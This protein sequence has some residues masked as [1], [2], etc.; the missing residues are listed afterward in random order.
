ML[1]SFPPL[2]LPDD[3]LSFE[4]EQFLGLVNK[5]CGNVFKELMEVLSINT[6]YKLLLVEKDIL[7]VFQKKY[8]ELEKITERACLHLDDGSILLKPGLRLDFDRFITALRAVYEGNHHQERTRSSNDDLLSLFTTLMKS[9]HVNENNNV[10]S[11][12]SFL[13]VFI[14]NILSNIFKNKNNYRYD[15]SVVHFAQSLYILG[16]RNA[17]EF[18]R[19]NLQGALPSLS[20]LDGTLTKSGM[21]FEEAEFRFNA[22]REHQKSSGYQTAVCSEDCTGVIKKITYNAMTNTFT[23]F[24]APLDHGLPIARHFQTDSF[25]QLKSWFETK[26]KSCYLNVHM[27][28]PLFESS[29]Y[30]SPFLLAAYGLS[31][32]FH[33]IDVLNRWL[34][35]LKKSRESDVR[36]VAFSTDCDSRY[37]LA[38]RLM[39][40]FFAKYNNTAIIDHDNT[41]EIHL[42]KGW[43]RWF[44]MPTQQIVF[45]FQDPAHLCTKLRNRIL[46]DTCSLL[47]GNEV[48][49][50]E[51]LMELIETKS[52]LLHGLVKT[53]INPKDRQNF[54]SCLNL[55]DDDVL[56]ALEDIDGSLA[57]RIY[58]RLLRSIVLAYVE[59]DTSIIDRIYHS[60]FGAFLC[61]IWQTWLHVVDETEISKSHSDEQIKDMFITTP[62]HFSVELNAHSLLGICLLVAQRK[63]PESALSISNYHSQSCESTFRLTRSMSGSFSSIVNFTIEQFLKRAGKLSVLTEIQN[64]SEMGKLKCSLEFPKHHKRRRKE[65]ILKGKIATSSG[66]SLTIEAIQG[67]IHRAFDDAY[68]LLSQANINIVLE[69]A[70]KN[71]MFEVSE[72]VRTQF[73]Q[74]FKRVSYDEGEKLSPDDEYDDEH[75]I[76]SSENVEGEDASEDEEDLCSISASGKTQFHGMRV[77]DNIPSSLTKSYFCVEIDGKKKYIHKQTACWVLTDE[78]ACLSSDRIKRVQEMSR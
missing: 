11:S 22:L 37:L 30:S 50:I 43:T 53:D 35:I 39:T 36:I 24:S 62:A 70:K 74:K 34:W 72:F 69:K 4:G 26:D 17:Y 32:K 8:R 21:L 76:N 56:H 78:K 49:S 55:S 52:K 18:V 7:S 2:V 45:C 27:I 61:R 58:L 12:S 54:T 23:G 6:V 66:S 25:D 29:P 60:W 5:T 33:A 20:V 15:E 47:I 44:F 28:Q 51:I 1:R 38:M 59:H 75:R 71:T 73:H 57:T 77:Y 48:V 19:L 3:V 63:L 9:F 14:E 13:T 10:K 42:P 40:R 46:S 67:A 31:N 16:G 64:L 65:A 68:D 41:L